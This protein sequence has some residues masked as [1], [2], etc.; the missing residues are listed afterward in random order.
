VLDRY[1][2]NLGVLQSAF[3][4]RTK[5]ANT[6]PQ[7]LADMILS[8]TGNSGNYFSSQD[9]NS[10]R[11]ELREDFSFKPVAAHGDHQISAGVETSRTATSGR[12]FARPV[13]MVDAN[14]T[15]LR[16]IEFRGGHPYATADLDV[17]SFVQDH[18]SLSKWLALDL[19]TRVEKQRLSDAL[20]IAP[21]IG[22]AANLTGD[23]GTVLRGGVGLFYQTVPLSAYVFAGYPRQVITTF[24]STGKIID[25]PRSFANVIDYAGRPLLPFWRVGNQPGNFVPSSA[26]WNLEVEQ[27]VGSHLKLRAGYLQSQSYGLLVV[28]PGKFRAKDA[29]LLSG[30]GKSQYRQIEL[31]TAV[32][33]KDRRTMFFSYVHSR[34]RG[35]LNQFGGYLGDLPYPVIQS[36]VFTNTAADVPNRFLTWGTIGLPLKLELAPTVEIRTG[37]PYAATDVLHQYVGIPN[38]DKSRFPKFF[39]FDARVSRDFAV[40]PKYGVRLSVT[41]LNLT[42]HFNALS[43]HSNVADPQFGTFFGTYPRRL[44]LDFDVLF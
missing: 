9:R 19:G 1:S 13:D 15:L 33:F 16:R 28:D 42:D 37:F 22:F 4:F 7:G 6:Q 2:F 18:W 3:G 38:S 26:A 43:V 10:V 5:D 30:T 23:L 27:P 17:S 36:G 21:R 11:Y 41:G 29:F 34:S 44:R 14:G 39:S 32:K 20:R 35:S 25:G 31:T 8:P 24:D 40:N 12:F